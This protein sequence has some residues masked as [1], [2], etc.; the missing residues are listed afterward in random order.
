L[1]DTSGSSARDP[2]GRLILERTLILYNYK[3]ITIFKSQSGEFR[4]LI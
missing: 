2:E 3:I 1:A 4:K